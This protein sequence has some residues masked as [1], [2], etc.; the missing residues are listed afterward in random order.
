LLDLRKLLI[1]KQLTCFFLFLLLIGCVIKNE[2]DIQGP[3]E[4]TNEGDVEA[5]DRPAHCYI[6]TQNKDTIKLQ[7][8]EIDQNIQGWMVYRFHEKDGAFGEVS[9]DRVGDTLRLTYEFLAEGTLSKM[10][11]YFL[12]DKTQLSLGDGDMYMSEDSIL[13][14]KNPSE[15]NFKDETAL[16]EMKSCSDE[17]ISEDAKSFFVKFKAES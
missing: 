4:L 6:F 5:I 7:I 17:F 12:M 11:K 1:M 14:Y 13:K 10:E 2:E 9:G 15:L 3:V 16:V 8:R